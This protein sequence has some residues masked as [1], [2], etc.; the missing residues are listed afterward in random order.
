MINPLLLL[1][2]LFSPGPAAL[3]GG[4]PLELTP[5]FVSPQLR[6]PPP[7][8]MSRARQPRSFAYMTAYEM[9]ST[10][11]A[12]TGFLHPAFELFADVLGRD[13]P[14]TGRRTT[15]RPSLAGVLF[16]KQVAMQIAAYVIEREAFL[17]DDERIVF[18]GVNLETSPSDAV[19]DS[20]ID[21]L[22]A[23]WLGTLPYPESARLLRE[24]FRAAES[25]SGTPAAYAVL[26]ALLLQHGALY[27][28]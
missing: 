6:S 27:F 28:Y 21:L 20:T 5:Q 2:S 15:D 9:Q 22:H 13:D 25:S 11:A 10:I 26:V 1:A 7:V 4:S 17:E 14:V 8:A 18:G 3:A 16:M 19:L 23:R 24:G 12:L